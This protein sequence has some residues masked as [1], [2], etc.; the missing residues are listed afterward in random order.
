MNVLVCV[1][2][3]PM[4][5]A[6]L[7]V[8]ADERS[9]DTRFWGFTVSPHEECAVEEAVRIG[10]AS[11]RVLTLGPPEAVEQLRD[12]LALG[13]GSALLL[14]TDV[15]EWGPEAT[16]DAIA[17]AVRGEQDAGRAPDL[18]LF[19]NEAAD[20]GDYQVVV[21]VAHLL[22]MPCLTGVKSL[23]VDGASVLLG[24]EYAGAAE[25]YRLPLPAVVGVREGLNL[26]RYPSLP[27][28][29]RAKKA[30]VDSVTPRAGTDRLLTRRLHVP[31]GANRQAEI[32]GHGAD[33]VPRIV[34]VLQTLGVVGR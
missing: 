21:R 13:I 20:T 29:I 19:G 18:L 16:A 15:E 28:R 30:P 26:P 1:K 6:S 27:G 12:A 24:R 33:A 3:V 34:E 32:L 17:S 31:A 25:S 4:V 11:S 22:G 23:T 10:G 14:A 2:R 7:S 9:L 8:L 5:G